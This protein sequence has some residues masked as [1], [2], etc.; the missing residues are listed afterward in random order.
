MLKDY[1]ATQLFLISSAVLLILVLITPLVREYH[2]FSAILDSVK[3]LAKVL[4]GFFLFF[5]AI[6]IIDS[7]RSHRHH[8]R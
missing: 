3:F 1:P 5:T 8:H 7:V 2:D 4:C 6:D